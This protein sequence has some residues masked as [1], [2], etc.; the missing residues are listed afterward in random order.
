MLIPPW[1]CQFN[2]GVD[3]KKHG[4]LLDLEWASSLAWFF[5]VFPDWEKGM[6]PSQY[7]TNKCYMSEW[8]GH[9]SQSLSNSTYFYNEYIKMLIEGYCLW[10][11]AKGTVWKQ[12][13]EAFVLFSLGFYLRYTSDSN[14]IPKAV[15]FTL[16]TERRNISNSITNDLCFKT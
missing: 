4:R 13:L 2:I 7:S 11:F 9:I 14:T 10:R 1:R 6:A 5:L 3:K 15:H 16:M 12:G 8:K